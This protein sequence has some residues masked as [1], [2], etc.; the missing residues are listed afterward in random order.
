MPKA[1]VNDRWISLIYSRRFASVRHQISKAV[2][3]EGALKGVI[4]GAFAEVVFFGG[5]FW[6][7]FG[8]EIR[9]RGA[10]KIFP[11][12]SEARMCVL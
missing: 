4:A 11:I 8:S 7:V 6:R 3:L 10:G 5:A 1:Q 12:R 9:P 2:A